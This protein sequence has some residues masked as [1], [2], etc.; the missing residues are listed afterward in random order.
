MNEVQ[1]LAV[2]ASARKSDGT[3]HKCFISYHVKDINEVKIFVDTFGEEFIPVTV[4][5]SEGDDFINSTNEDYIKERI[6][7]NYL[8]NSTV[9]IVL[10]GS[11]TWGRKYVDWEISSSLRND[12]VNKRNGLLLLTLPSMNGNARLPQRAEDNWSAGNL[13]TSYAK[14]YRTP[15]LHDKATLRSYIDDAF[16]ARATRDASVNNSRPL[17]QRNA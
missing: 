12:T 5:V 3:R 10:V 9:T 8:S 14:Y 16:Q 13:D 4:G 1:A 11:E 2:N 15:E 7:T 6:R 17:R